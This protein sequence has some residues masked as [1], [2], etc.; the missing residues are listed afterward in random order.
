VL[1]TRRT[2]ALL[3]IALAAACSSPEERA[4][5]ARAAVDQAIERGDRQAALGAIGDLRALANDSASAQLRLAQLL[6]RAGNAPEAGWLLEDVFRRHPDHAEV[7]LALARVSLL[8]GNPARAREVADGISGDAEPHFDA[9]VLRAQA[10]L[11]LGDLER[12]LATLAEA[13]RLYPDRPEARLVRIATLLSEDKK[14]EAR[15]AIEEA[16]AA[17]SDDEEKSRALRRRL[18]LTLA[19]LQAEQGETDDALA[20]IDAL[21]ESDP[22][23]LMAWRALV[24][25]LAKA[26]R[27]GEAL[28]RVEAA[29]AAD[30]APAQLHALAA[31]LHAGLGDDR[32]AEAE[33]RRYVE[34]A[35]SAAAYQPLVAFHSARGDAEATLAV[36]GEA[37]ARFPDEANLR[38][39]RTEA[40]LAADDLEEARAEMSRFE[41]ATFDGDPQLEYLDA[42]LALAEGDASGAAQRLTDLAPQ[43]DRAST[44]YWIGRALEQTGDPDGARRRYALAQRRDPAWTAP[45]AALIALDQRRGDWHAVAGQARTLV[46]RAPFE[47]SGWFSLVVALERLGQGEAAEQVAKQCLERFPDRPEPQLLMARALR[48]QGRTDDALTA[49][50]AAEEKG[51]TSEAAAARIRTLG[52]AGRVEEGVARGR[53][54]AARY[55]EAADVHA[56]LASLLFAA[57]AADEGARAT[58]RALELAPDEPAPLRERCVYRAATGRWAG[59]RDDCTRYLEARPEDAE[60]AFILGV[61]HEQLGEDDQ[62]VASYRRAAALD[63]RDA[64]PH[65]NLAG[66]LAARGDV[67][68]AL[69]AAQQAYRLDETNP[70]VMDTLGALY[71]KKGLVE[72]AISVLEDAHEGA[73]ELADAQ[74]HLGLAYRDAGRTEEARTLLASVGASASA[75]PELRASAREALDSLP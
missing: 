72:R 64:R 19:Q 52:M 31:Q 51:A 67:D 42:R 23:D 60:V 57:G 25:T 74:L 55:P 69:A 66:L 21:L 44:Q 48:A 30:D 3:S 33:L 5:K 10:E 1:R 49:L 61:A 4:E 24:Q 73:P 17:L 59:S 47:L 8:L 36:L 16:R 56:A 15:A 70:Y 46:A 34:S 65:N 20:A 9:L 35:D 68:G 54:A 32:A 40:L 50:A 71:L 58:D 12:A 7:S 62:A 53:A 2:A 13:E 18:D 63:E 39:Q 45:P 28:A 41:D 27:A 38:L 75:G 6:V 14:G 29:L 22:A 43:L 37:I 11:Q 26:K